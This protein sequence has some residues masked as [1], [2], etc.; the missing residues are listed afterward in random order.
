[1]TT[2][3]AP[4]SRTVDFPPPYDW[5]PLAEPCDLGDGSARVVGWLPYI[6]GF[7][8]DG[9][10]AVPVLRVD[11]VGD[12]H[13]FFARRGTPAP[14][15]V[16]GLAVAAERG[17]VR[18]RAGY[19]DGLQLVTT[20]DATDEQVPW[21][22]LDDGLVLISTGNWPTLDDGQLSLPEGTAVLPI[23]PDLAEQLDVARAITPQV[24][25]R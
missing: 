11:G 15:A 6:T 2:P 13:P 9:L 18:L 8:D 24:A 23:A 16:T 21:E 5:T 19:R 7:T 20:V 3:S 14:K 17:T 22:L 1:M 10:T 12:D 4:A 25:A